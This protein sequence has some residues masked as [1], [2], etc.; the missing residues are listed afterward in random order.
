[1]WLEINKQ[2]Q[3]CAPNAMDL[4]KKISYYWE[5]WYYMSVRNLLSFPNGILN[6]F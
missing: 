3:L 1:M 6:V 5:F 4:N 2:N